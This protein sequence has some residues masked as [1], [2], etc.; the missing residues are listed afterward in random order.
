MLDVPPQVSE[1]ELFSCS[2]ES[3]VTRGPYP[4]YT[5]GSNMALAKSPTSS[6]TARSQLVGTASCQVESVGD[7]VAVDFRGAAVE[8]AGVRLVREVDA[9]A[10]ALLV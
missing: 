8:D 4:A 2:A 5:A 6:C 1:S 7:P 10:P 3:R 9:A